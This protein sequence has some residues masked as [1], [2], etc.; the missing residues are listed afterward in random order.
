MG[1]ERDHPRPLRSLLLL[2]GLLPAQV[3]AEAQSPPDVGES[4]DT[5]VEITFVDVGQG[6]A[7]VVQGPDGVAMMVDAGSASPLQALSRL[8]V[9]SLALVVASHPHRDH[10]GGMDAVL[11]ARPVA[12]YLDSGVS[13]ESAL[14]ERLQATLDRLGAVE[15]LVAVDTTLRVGALTVEVLAPDDPAEGSVGL[16]VRHGAFS[17]FLPGDAEEDEL[18][19]WLRRGVVPDVT[20]LKASDGGSRAGFTHAFVEAVAPEMVVISVGAGNDQG[21]PRPE[22]MTAYRQHADPV[23]RT[24]LDG[25]ITV[26]GFPDGG[27]EVLTGETLDGRRL[28]PEPDAEPGPEPAGPVSIDVVVSAPGTRLHDLNGDYATITNQTDVT[29]DLSGWSLCDLTTRC[30]RFPTGTSLRP[31]RDVVVYTGYGYPDGVSFFQNNDRRVWNEN[32]DE[33]T[34]YDEAGR[35]VVRHVY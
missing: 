23:L 11:T 2:A 26:R 17:V 1:T 3:Q 15:Q 21:L 5:P 29:L 33:A 35:T 12:R 13:P 34:L 24:D 27:Y 20:V 7:I 32:G 4:S 6:D 9:D 8:G 28:R 30:F 19:A 14:H 31:G 18:A 10:I 22:A 25:H 16:I